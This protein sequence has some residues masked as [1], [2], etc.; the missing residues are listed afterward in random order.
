VLGGTLVRLQDQFVVDHVDEE[1][2]D[3]EL[4]PPLPYHRD[5]QFIPVGTAALY[6]V[7]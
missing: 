6:R 4:C 7:I 3:G 1:G 5:R 2:I